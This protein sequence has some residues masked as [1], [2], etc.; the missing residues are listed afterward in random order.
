MR[1]IFEELQSEVGRGRMERQHIAGRIGLIPDR[2]ARRQ[3]NRTRIVI[4]PHPS[5]GPKVMIK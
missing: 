1:Q 3:N 4:S 5:Q 2:I